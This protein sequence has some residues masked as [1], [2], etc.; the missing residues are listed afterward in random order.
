EHESFLDIL[1]PVDFCCVYGSSLHANN[2]SKASMVDCILGVNDPLKW[3][4]ENLKIN[5][6][7][8]ASLIV[9]VGGA[10]LITKIADNV[11][12]GVHFSP[13][14][15][16]RDSV[17]KFGVVGM[18]DLIQDMLGWE[19]FY[20]SGR[21]QKP[22]KVILDDMEIKEAN[23]I[24]LKAAA[25]AALLLL[26][27]KFSQEELYAHICS[28]SYM[29]DLRMLFAEDKNKVK[30][31]VGGQFKLLQA[32]YHPCLEEFA[33]RNLLRESSSSMDPKVSMTQDCGTCSTDSLVSYLPVPIR[34]QL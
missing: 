32:M 24:N 14:I 34:N 6:D 33:A 17:F 9:R 12:V 22:V 25:A 4:S 30:K 2:V 21:L 8:Y 27:A 29:G 18:H 7:H 26:P 23:S 20:L 3:H 31:I 15:S 11:G 1:P 19:S 13:F 10:Q 28:L 5:R 16:H